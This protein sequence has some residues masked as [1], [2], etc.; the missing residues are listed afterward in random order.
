MKDWANIDNCGSWEV[1]TLRFVI[2]FCRLL[3]LKGSKRQEFLKMTEEWRVGKGEGESL[4]DR[5]GGGFVLQHD[6]GGLIPDTTKSATFHG[7]GRWS[8]S[9]V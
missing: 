7:L 1:G 8:Q 4:K 5:M 9:P 6:F 2:P 3:C